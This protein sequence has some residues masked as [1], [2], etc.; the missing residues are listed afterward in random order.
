MSPGADFHAAATDIHTRRSTP[1]PHLVAPIESVERDESTSQRLL[2][3]PAPWHVSARSAHAKAWCGL[4]GESSA[5][6][7]VITQVKRVAPSDAA[8]LIEGESGVGKELV[9]R[10]IHSNSRRHGEF[11]ALNCGAVAQEL[12]MSQLFGHERGSFTGAAAR[13]I[14]YFEQACGGTLFLDEIT[15]MP[16]HLQVH[17]L[18]AL[19][20]RTV[21]RVG[22]ST[23]VEIDTRIVAA[24]NY[25]LG[26]AVADTRLREDLYYRL[27]EFP[28][29]VPPLRNRAEDVNALAQHFLARINERHGV[30][31][32]FT[33]S[34]LE[35]LRR[36]PWPGNVR[37]LRNAVGRA[38][39]MAADTAISDPLLEPRDLAP[40]G[41]TD[42][43]LTL[44]VGM[45][46][47]DMERRMLLKTLKYCHDDKTK[48]AR[49]L[50]VS[51]KT[52]HNKLA[53]YRTR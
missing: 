49:V 23:D 30:V 51:A 33:P 53:R 18:R 44:A 35:Q 32:S 3:C 41:E 50:G 25:P 21:R 10:A 1:H 19:E 7:Q 38:Y 48:A 14:G 24:T 36:Y 15:E 16:M 22:G 13:H 27:C 46:L 42:S 39:L 37:E 20:N 28:I 52:I 45:S 11:V 43:T 31:K 26:R 40:L 2:R 6:Q 8:V 12:L 34:A 9:A 17:L 47:E 29:T 4:V 5:L